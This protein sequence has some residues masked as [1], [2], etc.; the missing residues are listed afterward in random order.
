MFEIKQA[1]SDE[2]PER[3]PPPLCLSMRG[4]GSKGRR[5]PANASK[6]PEAAAGAPPAA[7]KLK[8]LLN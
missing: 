3:R 1:P 6:K 4:K 8:R 7:K 5:P 2:V